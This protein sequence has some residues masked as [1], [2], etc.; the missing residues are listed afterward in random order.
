M[1]PELEA[2]ILE[3]KKDSG[4]GRGTPPSLAHQEEEGSD[5]AFAYA[6]K[7]VKG[8]WPEYEAKMLTFAAS[9]AIKAGGYGSTDKYEPSH[10][11]YSYGHNRLPDRIKN[12]V[13]EVVQGRWNELEQV[14]LARY[15]EF[16]AEVDRKPEPR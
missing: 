4:D 16:A 1:W 7:V 2:E 12:Y 13:T 5:L 8:R 11:E 3:G 15:P 10:G 9:D 14:L 6:K